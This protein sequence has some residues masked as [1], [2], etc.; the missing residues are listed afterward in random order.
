[1]LQEVNRQLLLRGEEPISRDRFFDAL[2]VK[3]MLVKPLRRYTRTTDSYHRFR[4]YKNLLK[5]TTQ[6]GPNQAWAADIT[7]LRLITGF[8]YLFL[9]TDVF[10]RKIVGYHLS[11]SLKVEGAVKALKMAIKQCPNTEGVIHHSDRGIQYCCDPYV[12]TLVKTKIAISMTEENH[13]YEN[14]LA[15]RVNETLKYDLM[16]GERLPSF[17]VARQATNE[18][19]KIYNE[20][21]W[22]QSLE[23]LTPAVKHAA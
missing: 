17:S 8:C 1:M 16:L 5:N 10:S 2:R 12:A 11:R 6:T 14:A 23:Y 21:R 7:Y 13:C 3:D 22:H 4:T 18:A 15:E 19:I 9:I 20:E